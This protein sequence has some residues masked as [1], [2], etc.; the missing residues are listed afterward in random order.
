MPSVGSNSF[1][2]LFQER[3]V[4]DLSGRELLH[5]TVNIVNWLCVCR[6]VM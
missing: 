2:Y 4:K 6:L 5:T 3:K 1:R